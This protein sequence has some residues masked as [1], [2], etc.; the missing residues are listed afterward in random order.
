MGEQYQVE[1]K[2]YYINQALKINGHPISTTITL[3]SKSI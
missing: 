1:V 3:K 2:L